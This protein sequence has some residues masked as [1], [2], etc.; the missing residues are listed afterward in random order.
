MSALKISAKTA[1]A[2]A[3]A[4]LLSACAGPR[5]YVA[6]LTSPDGTLGQVTVTGPQGAQVLT[7]DHTAARTGR[8][9]AAV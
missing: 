8:Q 4:A 3:L 1:L 5:S 9:N 6:L 7:K 2:L